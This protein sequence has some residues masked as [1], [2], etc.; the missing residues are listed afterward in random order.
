MGCCGRRSAGGLLR[1]LSSCDSQVRARGSDCCQRK[2]DLAPIRGPRELG[3]PT[4]GHPWI[5]A[6]TSGLPIEDHDNEG[7][8]QVPAGSR[9]EH[10]ASRIP[11][12]NILC[13]ITCTTS[14]PLRLPAVFNIPVRTNLAPDAL[15]G[16]SG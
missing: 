12:T 7:A 10:T 4:T 3:K 1:L 11:D 6:G 8:S 16:N 2:P 5:G 15:D 9:S 13:R 14:I